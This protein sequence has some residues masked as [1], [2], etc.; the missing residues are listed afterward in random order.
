MATVTA[1]PPLPRLSPE[2]RRAAAGQFERANQVIA[3]G[4]L[5]YGIQLLLNCCRI[6]PVNPVY[7]Q[8]LR[9]TEKNKFGQ[10]RKGSFLGSLANWGT[11]RRMKSALR[12]GDHL[13]ALEFG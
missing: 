8:T 6:D 3:G 13:R 12:K 1:P 2:Q 11:R 9:Q 7:R 10:K 4:D 5:D